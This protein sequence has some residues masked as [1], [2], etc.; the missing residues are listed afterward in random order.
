[1]SCGRW[2]EP[3]T[4]KNCRL[5]IIMYSES[6]LLMLS[7]LQHIAFC[8]RQCALIHIE[9]AWS[10]NR[11]T[12]EGR[13]LHERVHGGNAES[14]GDVYIVRGLKLRSLALGLSGVADVVEFHRVEN[15]GNLIP[16][17]KG[18]WRPFPVEY[19]RGKPKKDSCDEVQLC[20][21]AMCLEEMLGTK[22]ENGALYYG[23]QHKRHEVIFN[24]SLRNATER[25]AQRLHELISKGVTP[26]AIY[27]KKCDHCSMMDICVPRAGKRKIVEKYLEEWI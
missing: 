19:K 12:A 14:R 13:I 3:N 27:E 5:E 21:Q 15:G 23:L 9:Q 2:P 16:G 17:K 8:E 10:E 7:A 20:G 25:T 24:E 1:M 22:I 11:L 18:L 26:P 4:A 6:D